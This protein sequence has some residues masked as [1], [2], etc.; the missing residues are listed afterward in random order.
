MWPIR[1]LSGQHNLPATGKEKLMP[2]SLPFYT[3]MALLPAVDATIWRTDEE[4]VLKHLL[5]PAGVGFL[6][7]NR[8]L[9]TVISHSFI[10]HAVNISDS[11]AACILCILHAVELKMPGKNSLRQASPSKVLHMCLA[12]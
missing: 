11:Q 7:G 4:P 8:Y 12:G 10:W 6:P 5:A 9:G 1:E 3:Y 2:A